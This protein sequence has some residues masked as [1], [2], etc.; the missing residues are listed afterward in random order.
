MALA[1]PLYI[2]QRALQ[3]A[4]EDR[5]LTDKQVTD[6]SC[7]LNRAYPVDDAPQE[8]FAQF[9]DLMRQDRPSVQEVPD[10]DR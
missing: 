2:L 9:I 7:M 10:G 3:H 8:M 4:A 1:N 6:I 5:S